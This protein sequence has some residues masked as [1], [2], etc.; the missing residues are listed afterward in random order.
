MNRS[1]RGRKEMFIA[2]IR[3][4]EKERVREKG[5]ARLV[6]IGDLPVYEFTKIIGKLS[7][8]SQTSIPHSYLHE[9]LSSM[10]KWSHGHLVN[11]KAL[12]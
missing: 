2:K 11:S 9:Y 5:R 4:R 3:E 6:S 1:Y 12:V 8:D 10:N 7:V